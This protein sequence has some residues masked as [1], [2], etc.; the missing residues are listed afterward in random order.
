MKESE[1]LIKNTEI[2][3]REVVYKNYN[4]SKHVLN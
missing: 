3:V 2:A 4:L 1:D